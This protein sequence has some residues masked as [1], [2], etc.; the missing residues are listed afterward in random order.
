MHSGRRSPDA[1]R[2]GA[3]VRRAARHGTKP[4]ARFWQPR[5]AGTLLGTLL[6]V[7]AMC[8]ACTSPE[9][10]RTRGGGPGADPGNRPDAVMMHGGSDPFWNTPDRIGE[11][12]EPPI[13]AARQARELSRP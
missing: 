10:E 7:C 4:A 11:D 8:A 12:H 1:T 2:G 9:A 3:P 5:A 13:A 6:I